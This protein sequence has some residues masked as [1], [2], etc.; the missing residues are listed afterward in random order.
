MLQAICLDDSIVSDLRFVFHSFSRILEKEVETL[1]SAT[2]K[3]LSNTYLYGTTWD[4]VVL[5]QGRL[6]TGAVFNIARKEKDGRKDRE[7]HLEAAR[8]RAI[9]GFELA[10]QLFKAQGDLSSS[11]ALIFSAWTNYVA[12]TKKYYQLNEYRHP[13]G[14]HIIFVGWYGPNG[15]M[16]LETN[17]ALHDRELTVE[18][19]GHVCR[20]TMS[21][22]SRTTPEILPQ[23]WISLPRPGGST[24]S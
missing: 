10:M 12:H 14:V 16:H 11:S 6:T 15:A 19:I 17:I 23:A 18:Q 20:C 9:G 7:R 3:I 5:L 1:N 2:D 13:E 24:T 22:I 21:T 8:P 4:G